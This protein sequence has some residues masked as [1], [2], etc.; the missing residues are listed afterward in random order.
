MYKSNTMEKTYVLRNLY[1]IITNNQGYIADFVRWAEFS[2]I[3]NRFYNFG[4]TKIQ[5]ISNQ[6]NSFPVLF[7]KNNLQIRT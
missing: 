1:F 2:E 3:E 4:A 5:F 7:I 6:C